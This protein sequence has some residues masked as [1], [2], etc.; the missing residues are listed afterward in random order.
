VT[1]IS[2][3][4]LTLDTSTLDLEGIN[5][6]GMLKATV[7]PSN[8]TNKKINWSSDNTSVA[9]VDI[10]GKVTAIS[11][12]TATITAISED[13]SKTASATVT[14]LDSVE[15]ISVKEVKLNKTSINLTGV[16][17]EEKLTATIYPG[18]ATNKNVIWKSSN[19]AVATVS[20]DGIVKAVGAGIAT[21]T[22]TTVDGSISAIATFTVTVPNSEVKSLDLNLLVVGGVGL[23]LI[24]A[25][26]IVINIMYGVRGLI[27]GTLLIIKKIVF[28]VAR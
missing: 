17:I 23:L 9:T 13:G 20:S 16:G 10:N 21:I 8:A 25:L 3:T 22:T 14:V 5:S 12:G 7:V 26:L 28:K 11:A 2:V 6:I 27:L 18:D 24:S 4:G 15:V 19:T 1:A